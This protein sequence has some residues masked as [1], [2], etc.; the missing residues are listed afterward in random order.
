MRSSRAY[1]IVEA[2]IDFDAVVEDWQLALDAAGRALTAAEHDLPADEL[3]AR[4]RRLA[5]ERIEVE[6]DLQALGVAGSGL[7]ARAARRLVGFRPCSARSRRATSSTTTG[8]GS[9]A[10]RSTPTSAAC[11]TGQ[12]DG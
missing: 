12:R 6:R 1:A 7:V 5:A 11:R 3:H 9:T 4:R 2:M 8:R 10:R